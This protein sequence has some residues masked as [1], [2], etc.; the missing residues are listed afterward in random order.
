VV[1]GAVGGAAIG[2]PIKKCPGVRTKSSESVD[3]IGVIG[4]EFITASIST[5]IDASS[6]TRRMWDWWIG[7]GMNLHSM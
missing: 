5:N 4:R 6:F 7:G 1:V 2:R 3:S